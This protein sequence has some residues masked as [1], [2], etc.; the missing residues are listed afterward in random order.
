MVERVHEYRRG[1]RNLQPPQLRGAWQE[2]TQAILTEHN[3]TILR[4]ISYQLTLLLRERDIH[5]EQDHEHERKSHR[6]D[7]DR[8][9]SDIA[10]KHG[11]IRYGQPANPIAH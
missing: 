2:A 1:R 6:D 3:V 7:D 9:E 11:G 4:D 5:R 8:N 10:Y